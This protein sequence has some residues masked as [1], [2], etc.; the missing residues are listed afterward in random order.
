MAL[1]LGLY[2][3]LTNE[4]YC[5]QPAQQL[6][7]MKRTASMLL[8]AWACFA[9]GNTPPPGPTATYVDRYAD[10]AMR[11]MRSFGIPASI[12]LAQGILE[13]QSGTSSA[14]L[15]NHAHFGIKAGHNWQGPTF[16]KFDDE[17]NK[18]GQKIESWFRSYTS[19][20]DSYLD[21]CKYLLENKR[22]AQLFKLHPA[23]YWAWAFELQRAYY[24]SDASYAKKLFG[25]IESNGLFR[26]DHEVRSEFFSA[27][28]LP[29]TEQPLKPT[30]GWQTK[31]SAPAPPAP[32]IIEPA[33]FVQPAKP[34]DTLN[35]LDESSFN[36][37]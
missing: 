32:E 13:S 1:A 20:E 31:G 29:E 19:D 4:S 6:H 21:H 36:H 18:Q 16:K 2:Y 26:F 30:N 33:L 25:I 15:T 22:Y 27:N 12:K 28:P 24:A 7:T 37:R 10:L 23:D 8:I 9:R 17:Y 5:S 11:H 14:C 34:E 35:R 3:S